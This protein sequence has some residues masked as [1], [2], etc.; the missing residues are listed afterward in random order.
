MGRPFTWKILRFETLLMSD[1][2]NLASGAGCH[3][4]IQPVL[5]ICFF[6]VFLF[7][8]ST[9]LY[10]STILYQNSL[11]FTA[12]RHEHQQPG[13]YNHRARTRVTR[14]A[15]SFLQAVNTIITQRS[16]LGLAVAHFG[17][18]GSSDSWWLRTLQGSAAWDLMPARASSLTTKSVSFSRQN[19]LLLC[20]NVKL[21]LILFESMKLRWN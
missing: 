13:E 4:G 7:A 1:I 19:A 3:T 21:N 6:M 2:W 10:Q 16:P 20:T 15:N 8:G 9:A 17:N 18:G 5:F 11:W 12:R 14:A